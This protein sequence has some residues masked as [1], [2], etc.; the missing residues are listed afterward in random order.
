[1]RKPAPSPAL[2]ERAGV[3]VQ[4]QVVVGNI[5]LM[6]IHRQVLDVIRLGRFGTHPHPNPPA[7][8]GEA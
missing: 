3:R 1:M 8:D 7:F 4:R 2:R 5:S 6:L